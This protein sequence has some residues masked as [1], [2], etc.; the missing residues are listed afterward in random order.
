M[1]SS[2][3]RQKLLGDEKRILS[4]KRK[5]EFPTNEAFPSGYI[6]CKGHNGLTGFINFRKYTDFNE[7]TVFAYCAF[8]LFYG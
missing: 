7:K 5:T 8:C 4:S 2:A 1:I 3:D 6:G